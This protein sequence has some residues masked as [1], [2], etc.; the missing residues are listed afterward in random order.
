M[1]GCGTRSKGHT[2]CFGKEDGKVGCAFCVSGTAG[3][4]GAGGGCGGER[5]SGCPREAD[6]CL[7]VE[8]SAY[9]TMVGDE[10]C[11][12]ALNLLAKKGLRRSRGDT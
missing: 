12:S 7:L 10:E 4:E 6:R 1:R 8:N 9:I 11:W 2:E 5:W 3:Q